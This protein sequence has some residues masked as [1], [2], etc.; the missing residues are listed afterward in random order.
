VADRVGSL[1]GP[2][3]T[4]S[5]RGP[6][7]TSMGGYPF[8]MARTTPPVNPELTTAFGPGL[9]VS[10]PETPEIGTIW[11]AGHIEVALAGN[12][13]ERRLRALWRKRQGNRA[14]PLLVVVPAGDSQVRLLGPQRPEDPIREIALDSL[15]MTLTELQAKSRRDA[16]AGLQ[17]ALE[18][19]DRGGV[20]G[21]VIRGL[22][23]RHVL[24]RRLRRNHPDRWK[25]LEEA[26]EKLKPAHSW[27]ENLAALGYDIEA[28]PTRGHVLRHDG[29]PVAVVHPF[30]DPAAFSRMTAEGSTPE[31]LLV[32]DCRAE[33]VA[34]GLL[35]TDSR[36]RLFPA[37]TSVGAATARYL[38]MDIT[39]TQPAD[40]TYLGLLAPESLEHGGLLERLVE[41]ADRLGNEL[42]EDVERRIRDEA[43]LSITRGL[44]DHQRKGGHDLSSPASRQ[45]NEDAALLVVFRLIFL[46]WLEGR[47]YLPLASAAYASHSATQLLRDA[48]TQAPGF[49]DRATTLWDRFTTLVNAMR[50]G[51]TAWGLP[52]YDGDLFAQ[53]VLEGAELLEE[54][55]LTDA[56]FGPALAALGHDPEGEEAQAGVDFGDLEIAHLG[57]IYEGL[58]SLRLSLATE[59]MA[60]DPGADRWMPVGRREPE[61]PE[62]ELFFQ[63]TSGGRKAAGVYYTP[64][65]LVRHLVDHAVFP[66]LEAHLER[67]AAE[68]NA[69]RAAEMLFDFKVLDPAMGSAHF[70]ADALDRIAERIGTFLAERPLKP[71]TALLDELRAE[72]TWEGRIEDGDLLRR[73]I[74]KRCIYGV[75][76]S[77]MAVEVGK[78]SLWLASFVPGLPLAYLGHNLKQGDALVGVADPE[79]LAD[80]GPVFAEHPN[81]PIPRA[82]LKAREVA[83][84]I[85]ETSDRTPEE[86]EASRKSQIELDQLTEGLDHLFS[87]WSAEPLGLRGARSWLGG[88]AEKVL[89]GEA[90]KGEDDFLAPA[91]EMAAERTFLHWP[92]AFPEAFARENP[93]FDVVIGNPPWEELTVEELA[94]Y[95]LHDPGIRGLRAEADRRKRI[96]DLQER[97]PGLQKEFEE[98][99]RDLQEKRRFFGPQGGYVLQGAGDTDLHKL[100]SERYRSLTRTGGWLGVVLPRSAF[101]VD[102]ARGFRRWVFDQNEMRRLDFILN[103]GRWAFDME[104][105][106]TISLVSARGTDRSEASEVHLTGPSPSQETFER[107]SSSDGIPVAYEQLATWTRRADGPG[108]EVP[109]LPSPESVPVFD[110]VRA[111]PGFGEGYKGVWSAFPVAELHE[112]ADKMLFRH[113]DGV[114]V[115]KGRSFDQFDPH[116]ADP[117]GFAA[118]AEAMER[119]QSKRLRSRVFRDRFSQEFLEDPD[120][121]PFYSARVAFRDVTRAT[122]SRTVRAALVPPRIFLTNSGPYLVATQGSAREVAFVL[123]VL[124]ST[125]FDWQARRFVEIHMNFYILDLLCFPPPEAT[126]IDGIAQRAA[127]LSCVDERFAGFAETAGIEHGPLDPEKRNGLRAEIDALVAR[128]YGLTADDLDVVFSDFTEKAAPSDYRELVR[129]AFAAR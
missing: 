9:P 71:V 55:T 40:W 17:T 50:S 56:R 117:A 3:A 33:N 92:V 87:V 10:D 96:V 77:R 32:A 63:S 70:L 76:L 75:D 73:L 103:A 49:D 47:G 62:G 24:T 107:A 91:L 86:V 90:A 13:N 25:A 112:T 94:F 30:A 61:I 34:W 122:D 129:D 99:Q 48:R 128:A 93:G 18:R 126:D 58:L 106:Y 38:E 89:A 66:A 29:R 83:V 102:G 124:N 65:V 118:E 104:P 19:L 68:S 5:N 28:R 8:P 51:N 111:G 6:F 1:R 2:R 114:P 84:R 23:T 22:L 36:F 100:F 101:L 110:K 52:A 81:A 98:R 46:L 20:P 80:L 125:P 12:V 4:C 119:L 116:G 105:R 45:L 14:K 16:V 74:L 39:V 78:V 109:L 123:G 7:Q 95:A 82:L 54:A 67:V 43:L 108:Y 121:H 72:A 26:A 88:A 31:G 127:R 37:E 35:A 69:K 60:Y 113:E 42:R 97:Y 41:E 64:Q 44:G 79:V 115:W 15:I 21:I 27:R 59:P 57:R 85:A 120:T 11:N 53:D